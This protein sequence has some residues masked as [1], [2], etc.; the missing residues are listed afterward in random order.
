MIMSTSKSFM[1]RCA[2][3]YRKR[4]TVCLCLNL[5]EEVTSFLWLKKEAVTGKQST[6]QRVAI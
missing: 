1:S 5:D 6:H 2:L 4:K 3:T